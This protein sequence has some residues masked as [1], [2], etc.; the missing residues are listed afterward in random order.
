MANSDDSKRL[1]DLT[2]ASREEKARYLHTVGGRAV[3]R[4]LI[5]DIDKDEGALCAFQSFSSTD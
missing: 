1:P 5:N 2:T 3:L 4:R